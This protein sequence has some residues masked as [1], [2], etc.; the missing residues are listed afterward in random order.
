MNDFLPIYLGLIG[1]GAI[2]F[3]I[4]FLLT[5]KEPRMPKEKKLPSPICK[6]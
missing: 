4:K 5:G 3:V 6:K 1:I 2:F